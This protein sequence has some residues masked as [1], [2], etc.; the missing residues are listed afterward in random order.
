[1]LQ[2]IANLRAG[3]E[4]GEVGVEWLHLDDTALGF[5]LEEGG[6][7]GT[8]FLE[9]FQREESPIGNASTVVRGVDDSADLRLQGIADGIEQL[10]KGGIPARLGDTD[11]GDEVELVE[12]VGDGMGHSGEMVGRHPKKGKESVRFTKQP[13]LQ[14]TLLPSVPFRCAPILN[15]STPRNLP[16]QHHAAG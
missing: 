13:P 15:T 10:G 5:L 16:G 4:G 9:I 1:M 7:I 6:R 2:V 11:A 12:I 8:V 14:L 3:F